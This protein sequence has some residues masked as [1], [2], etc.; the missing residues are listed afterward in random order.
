[1]IGRRLRCDMSA[2]ASSSLP[3]APVAAMSAAPC[4]SDG[5]LS[6]AGQE[7][8][9]LL[10]KPLRRF[11]SLLQ[12]VLAKLKATAADG[13]TGSN[14]PDAFAEEYNEFITVLLQ[15]MQPPIHAITTRQLQGHGNIDDPQLLTDLAQTL[16]RMLRWKGAGASDS[17]SLSSEAEELCADLLLSGFEAFFPSIAERVAA[18]HSLSRQA[19][20]SDARPGGSR[21]SVSFALEAL[22]RRYSG[23][24]DAAPDAAVPALSGILFAV[25]DRS[26]A[27]A[28][29]FEQVSTLLLQVA[30][31]DWH[32]AAAA[33]A[34]LPSKQ[35]PRGRTV[36]CIASHTNFIAVFLSQLYA[37]LDWS[38]EEPVCDAAAPAEETSAAAAAASAVTPTLPLF[39]QLQHTLFLHCID[40]L[41]YTQHIAAGGDSAAL[42]S[43]FHESQLARLLHFAVPL[44]TRILQRLSEGADPLCWTS[45]QV[46]DLVQ[47]ALSLLCR[48]GALDDRESHAAASTALAA[49]SLPFAFRGAQL[50]H[51]LALLL[52]S[53][54]FTTTVFRSEAA[55]STAPPGGGGKLHNVLVPFAQRVLTGVFFRFARNSRRQLLQSTPRGQRSTVPLDTVTMSRDEFCAFYSLCNAPVTFPSVMGATAEALTAKTPAAAPIAVSAAPPTLVLPTPAAAPTAALSSTATPA[56]SFSLPSA[57]ATLHRSHTASALSS[58]LP[59]PGD[60]P[61][62]GASQPLA[63]ALVPASAAQF[64]AVAEFRKALR[65]GSGPAPSV[66]SAQAQLSLEAFLGWNLAAFVQ[67]ARGK[68]EQLRHLYEATAPDAQSSTGWDDDIEDADKD[69]EAKS[70]QQA[71]PHVATGQ[72]LQQ[73]LAA[74]GTLLKQQVFPA[75]PAVAPS[76]AAELGSTAAT[77]SAAPTPA[78][79]GAALDDMATLRPMSSTALLTPSNAATAAAATISSEATSAASSAAAAAAASALDEFIPRLLDSESRWTQQPLHGVFLAFVDKFTQ[80]PDPQQPTT[81][82][83]RKSAGASPAARDNAAASQPASKAVA[84]TSAVP[85]QAKATTSAWLATPAPVDVGAATLLAAHADTPMVP[86]PALVEESMKLPP[87][88]AESKV[89]S[90]GSAGEHKSN[91]GG[92]G[93]ATK[94]QLLQST[95]TPASLPPSLQPL[96]SPQPSPLPAPSPVVPDPLPSQLQSSDGVSV[97]SISSSAATSSEFPGGELEEPARCLSS[98]FLR[99]LSEMGGGSAKKKVEEWRDALRAEKAF[100]AACIKHNGLSAEVTQYSGS[101]AAVELLRLALSVHPLTGLPRVRLLSHPTCPQWMK[102][103]VQSTFTEVRAPLLHL[104]RGI[105]E[106]EEVLNEPP[107]ADADADAQSTT[108]S[109]APIV[110]FTAGAVNVKALPRTLAGKK[111]LR[112]IRRLAAQSRALVQR[113]LNNSLFL[114]RELDVIGKEQLHPL[115]EASATPAP[116]PSTS[117]I[118]EESEET[119]DEQSESESEEDNEEEEEAEDV[120]ELP[121]RFVAFAAQPSGGNMTMPT[122][123]RTVGAPSNASPVGGSSSFSSQAETSANS[124]ASALQLPAHLLN[125]AAFRGDSSTRRR[126]RG[127]LGDGSGG[128]GAASSLATA[129]TMRESAS[130]AALEKQ[131]GAHGLRSADSMVA[132]LAR[133]VGGVAGPSLLER[134]QSEIVRRRRHSVLTISPDMQDASSTLDSDANGADGVSTSNISSYL[135]SLGASDSGQHGQVKGGAAGGASANSLWSSWST[136]ASQ[137]NG[138]APYDAKW[139]SKLVHCGADLTP[140]LP[141]SSLAA[142]ARTL[143]IKPAV[144]LPSLRDVLHPSIRRF[145]SVCLLR[146]RLLGWLNQCFTAGFGTPI[147]AH[148]FPLLVTCLSRL[149]G[150]A[151]LLHYGK[152]IVHR[153]NQGG[154]YGHVLLHFYKHVVNAINAQ[155]ADAPGSIEATSAVSRSQ[156]I[157]PAAVEGGVKGGVTATSPVSYSDPAW[158]RIRSCLQLLRLDFLAED[159]ESIVGSGVF[160]ALFR[161]IQHIDASIQAAV[162]ADAAPVRS[163]NAS[164]AMSGIGDMSGVPPLQ[165]DGR[166]LGTRSSSGGSLLSLP[167]APEL[168]SAKSGGSVAP[169]AAAS[170]STLSSDSA[171]PITLRY[172]SAYHLKFQCWQTLKFLTLFVLAQRQRSGGTNTTTSGLSSG[173]GQ[174]TGGGNTANSNSVLL[175][176]VARQFVQLIVHQLSVMAAAPP[177]LP[178]QH[179][180]GSLMYTMDCARILCQ[181][182][183]LKAVC[184]VQQLRQL[185]HLGTAAPAAIR[186]VLVQLVA[187]ELHHIPPVDLDTVPLSTPLSSVNASPVL[188]PAPAPSTS[189]A[190]SVSAGSVA[191]DFVQQILERIRQLLVANTVLPSICQLDASVS[192]P[193]TSPAQ[194]RQQSIN[195]VPT[196]LSPV[197]VGRSAPNFSGSASPVERGGSYP[198]FLPPNGDRHSR[199]TSASRTGPAAVVAADVGSRPPFW[200]ESGYQSWRFYPHFH[201]CSGQ[202]SESALVEELITALRSLALDKRW[203]PVVMAQL[204][205]QVMQLPAALQQL[206]SLAADATS[207]AGMA[208][209]DV[210][211]NLD[212]SFTA[213]LAALSVLGGHTFALRRGALVEVML[214][215]RRSVRGRVRQIDQ[216]LCRVL[217]RL[218]PSQPYTVQRPYGRSSASSS[219]SGASKGDHDF[220]PAPATEQEFSFD[221]VRVWPVL[222]APLLSDL[223]RATEL[224]SCVRECLQ[225]AADLPEQ[226]ADSTSAEPASVPMLLCVQT[227]KALV[228]LLHS[229]LLSSLSKSRARGAATS[230]ATEASMSGGALAGASVSAQGSPSLSPMPPAADPTERLELSSYPLAL[231]P[232]PSSPPSLSPEPQSAG[233]RGGSILGQLQGSSQDAK[234]RDSGVSVAL[235]AV[236]SAMQ[237]TAAPSLAR[238]GP[239]S[240]KFEAQLVSAV[241]APMDFASFLPLLLRLSERAPHAV[242]SL[243]LPEMERAS[244][245]LSRRLWEVRRAEIKHE[246]L[247]EASVA[248][249]EDTSAKSSASKRQH[250]RRSSALMQ[251][252]RQDPALAERVAFIPFTEAADKASASGATSSRQP[253]VVAL[254]SFF[255]THSLLQIRGVATHT[256][257][258][259]S[260]ALPR[261]MIFPLLAGA[262]HNADDEQQPQD[263]AGIVVVQVPPAGIAFQKEASAAATKGKESPPSAVVPRLLTLAELGLSAAVAEAI[264]PLRPAGPVPA[265]T[266]SQSSASSSQQQHCDLEEAEAEALE[267]VLGDGC[268]PSS[269]SAEQ[270]HRELENASARSGGIHDTAAASAAPPGVM[271]TPHRG[272][273]AVTPRRVIIGPYGQAAVL[274]S[275]TPASSRPGSPNVWQKRLTL[276]IPGAE[277]SASTASA[278]GAARNNPQASSAATTASG[279]GEEASAASTSDGDNTAG[280]GGV[281]HLQAK[282]VRTTTQAERQTLL[283]HIARA[284]AQ[285]PSDPSQWRLYDFV[286]ARDV[287]GD[288]YL[289]QVIA[290]KHAATEA[291]SH[292]GAGGER[293]AV[294]VHFFAWDDMYREWISLDHFLPAKPD[295]RRPTPPPHLARLRAASLFQASLERLEADRFIR[296]VKVFGREVVAAMKAEREQAAILLARDQAKQ[297]AGVALSDPYSYPLSCAVGGGGGSNPACVEPRSEH[298]GG[299]QLGTQ[300][301]LTAGAIELLSLQLGRGILALETEYRKGDRLMVLD[302]VNKLCEAEVLECRFGSAAGGGATAGGEILIHYI[303]WPSKWDEVLP[304]S[305]ERIQSKRGFGGAATSTFKRHRSSGSDDAFADDEDLGASSLASRAGS[306]WNGPGGHAAQLIGLV[307]EHAVITKL[308]KAPRSFEEMMGGTNANEPAE[309]EQR[310][311]RK[312]PQPIAGSDT[313]AQV[314]LLDPVYGSLVCFWTRLHLLRRMDDVD[315]AHLSLPGL[316]RCNSTQIR[317]AL[318]RNERDVLGHRV[319]QLVQHIVRAQT[320]SE[321]AALGSST[322]GAAQ[323]AAGHVAS[324]DLPLS[325]TVLLDPMGA[326]SSSAAAAGASSGGSGTTGG[327]AQALDLLS[328]PAGG[329]SLPSLPNVRP[330]GWGAATESSGTDALSWPAQFQSA[331]KPEA[332]TDSSAATVQAGPDSST[333]AALF[334]RLLSSLPRVSQLVLS[335]QPP[336]SSGVLPSVSSAHNTCETALVVH[337][338]HRPALTM[339]SMRDAEQKAQ[340]EHVFVPEPEEEKKEGEEGKQSE[341]AAEPSQAQQPNMP[342]GQ[343]ASIPSLQRSS[344]PRSASALAPDPDSSGASDPLVQQA[345]LSERM[346]RN[347]TG[348]EWE[349]LSVMGS[350]TALILQQPTSGAQSESTEPKLTLEH[351]AFLTKQCAELTEALMTQF[352]PVR[353]MSAHAN[354]RMS[355]A[356]AA[357]ASS[358]HSLAGTSSSSSGSAIDALSEVHIQ[359]IRPGDVVRLSSALPGAEALQVSWTRSSQPNFEVEFVT[360]AEESGAQLTAEQLA[361]QL[362]IEVPS[363][364]ASSAAPT[365]TAKI[366]PLVHLKSVPVL[367]TGA[368]SLIVPNPCFLLASRPSAAAVAAAEGRKAPGKAA[369][370]DEETEA[371]DDDFGILVAPFS[372]RPLESLASFSEVL[373]H[374]RREVRTTPTLLPTEQ[375]AATL[376]ALEQVMLRLWTNWCDW[377]VRFHTLCPWPCARFKGL[378]FEIVAHLSCELSA[379]LQGDAASLE[380]IAAS[381]QLLA[382]MQP[383]S[384][385]WISPLLSEARDRYVAEKENWPLFSSYLQR[386][387]EMLVALM[388]LERTVQH[389]MDKRDQQAPAVTA[390]VHKSASS[391]APLQH[392][393]FV[394]PAAVNTGSLLHNLSG[395]SPP[396]PHPSPASSIFS[397]DYDE[398]EIPGGGDSRR[399][400]LVAAAPAS[401]DDYEARY[402]ASSSPSVS[403]SNAHTGGRQSPPSVYTTPHPAGDE[404]D[405][406]HQAHHSGGGASASPSPS[407]ASLVR[408][409]LPVLTDVFELILLKRHLFQRMLPPSSAPRCACNDCKLTRGEHPALD[410]ALMLLDFH[411]SVWPQMLGGSVLMLPH[412]ARYRLFDELLNVTA[413]PERWLPEFPFTTLKERALAKELAADVASGGSSGLAS[414]G[415]STG[416]SASSGDSGVGDDDSDSTWQ[417][418]CKAL[419]VTP[420]AHL[421][422]KLGDVT[423]KARF[424]GLHNRGAEGLPGPFRQSLTEIC[425]DLRAA[426]AAGLPGSILIP[427]PN[428]VF[429]TGLDRNKLILHPGA[430][431]FDG[432]DSCYRFGQL[433]GVAIRSQ[434]VLDVDMAALLWKL[435]ADERL[436]MLDLASIDYTAYKQLQWRSEESG[437]SFTEEEF[438]DSVADSLTWSTTLSDGRTRVELV[439]GGASKPVTFAQRTKY[440][441]AVLRARL[442]ESRLAVN[443]IRAGL[444]SVVPQRACELLT[445]R[446]LEQRVCGSPQLDLDLL[447]KHTVYAPRKF[448]A[449]SPVV[450]NFWRALR[451][452]TPE[453]QAK[454]MQFAWAR[455]RLPPASG[456]DA[457]WRM[458][459]NILEAAGA[460]DLPTCETC[461]FNVNLPMYKDFDTLFA[462]LQLAITHC[463]SINS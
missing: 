254:Q 438:M 363:S 366:V 11:F 23:A 327:I 39:F 190:G 62:A 387:V 90:D 138:R 242:L 404:H 22:A 456:R 436:G 292:A 100:A 461:F 284:V 440:A 197:F 142:S 239:S 87:A 238:A 144:K 203:A 17:P 213:G 76:A 392:P 286:D 390:T 98:L 290:F 255:D 325:P 354:S 215:G 131:S 41:D 382:S 241:S 265:A 46:G 377:L 149:K 25:P 320:T 126:R 28:G 26:I 233:S 21:A 113:V 182:T 229:Q 427:S 326:I 150:D 334:S 79:H 170:S 18:V 340:R 178:L 384:L 108:S 119:E 248:P 375:H 9:L 376:A 155:L 298:T 455:S 259:K 388:Q 34:Q 56:M 283:K 319:A 266:S 407:L 227:Q 437:E 322:S 295:G 263:E 302:T 95:G 107:P 201:A 226:A 256:L 462:K 336:C 118:A 339:E 450:V 188:G 245:L 269:W 331:L 362:R 341:Q 250:S 68:L 196:V 257:G 136:S 444:F 8:S 358:M 391:A 33:S 80:Q 45:A 360:A 346:Y 211:S 449:S 189:S 419:R 199:D 267:I 337:P 175:S 172:A 379:S 114:L 31:S 439:A 104:M 426:A 365:T 393:R 176:S 91:G 381:S 198:D 158:L 125:S 369:A 431:T 7:S 421:R 146:V 374:L 224:W 402:S 398:S 273:I 261:F 3:A 129:P 247:W 364:G 353:K 460:K 181:F 70:Q 117:P 154:G 192:L 308:A 55:G 457:T 357:A 414:P 251:Q 38:G 329:A 204:Q 167:A 342:T 206:A 237:S 82:S 75:S 321:G 330:G 32:A 280:A 425:A 347:L 296:R 370:A 316:L 173:D 10:V 282:F 5:A 106:E 15:A 135:R 271:A 214:H 218:S 147:V 134:Q 152:L 417:Q 435:L 187:A 88:P 4:Q 264:L 371:A 394:R 275:A 359:T 102:A 442:E 169:Q 24:V 243:S 328:P 52:E 54:Q 143:S 313:L 186:T 428:F 116:G 373:L 42:P 78:A 306:S 228:Q 412:A 159:T 177:K 432:G 84:K 338:R 16:Q 110:T 137:R 94:L 184:S 195:G 262:R 378:V 401:S 163:V 249:T 180:D 458:K 14:L 35:R 217:V 235:H 232:I 121:Q 112:S 420:E 105:E 77:G 89:N 141:S 194:S 13:A 96:E 352:Q 51:M 165:L 101:V 459:L 185:L 253:L 200:F 220:V 304:V 128:I 50:R 246:R 120:A 153:Q 278:V 451:T 318:Q 307:G 145:Q 127:Q 281:G 244:A 103:V 287:Y 160:A 367:R 19:L 294:L 355:A 301:L 372:T 43:T 285:Q 29:V 236:P 406:R 405:H 166:V 258:A 6:L 2:G 345:W 411:S 423:W 385:A 124:T 171:L 93:E 123:Y 209:T 122:R 413:S 317:A 429:D 443:H 157:D 351:V 71:K 61:S 274:T 441:R 260:G 47:S 37:S 293:V 222:A 416:A 223:P 240:S 139:L 99:C 161:T 20:R 74:Y 202:A 44:L 291:G 299:L 40:L 162:A 49:C 272:H 361:H 400:S 348:V 270:W 418:L 314:Q 140:P 164:P 343:V 335:S 268:D 310:A 179:E 57:L 252:M 403:S 344:S 151:H 208:S 183:K 356:A 73:L 72:L 424:K 463:S 422:G 1:M 69:D 48:I 205:N 210:A 430:A 447:A 454:F 305:S 12:R 83:S 277:S 312:P 97:S 315:V 445:W 67:D 395:P 63:T 133:P 92:N 234:Q 156:D 27:A 309:T 115:M 446:E 212:H 207:S 148:V 368:S 58:R 111:A 168:Q 193:A 86:S 132:S 397:D 349:K 380:Q 452:F 174:P 65:S 410:A 231:S 386:M 434:G 53:H 323:L 300:V 30:R 324:G 216:H 383:F 85:F 36:Q 60:G 81:A 415:S 333:F 332:S 288:W 453:E 230:L 350:L 399:A 311:G 279:I 191:A 409:E 408:T 276:Q 225:L 109:A 448:T 59:A 66:P 289:A 221:Q 433:L 64:Q 219:S 303:G 389:Q 297:L 130:S 396:Q